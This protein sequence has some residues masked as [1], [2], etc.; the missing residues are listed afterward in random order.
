MESHS[1]W[2]P[3][4]V[5]DEQEIPFVLLTY[6]WV[7]NKIEYTVENIAIASPMLHR[8]VRGHRS[9]NSSAI[10][11]KHRRYLKEHVGNIAD[12]SPMYRLVDMS[13]MFWRHFE[14][15]CTSPNVRRLLCAA[16]CFFSAIDRRWFLA[17]KHREKLQCSH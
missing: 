15:W 6:Y 8:A 9:P 3:N 1:L 10:S 13:Q 16:W 5:M 2:L 7:G 17:T 4:E 14:P 11:N 12:V